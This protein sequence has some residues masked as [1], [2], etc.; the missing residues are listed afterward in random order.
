MTNFLTFLRKFSKGHVDVY[1]DTDSEH[2]KLS[3]HEYHPCLLKIET[4]K[5]KK[6]PFKKLAKDFI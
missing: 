6:N 1:D 3:N 2:A 4:K 5:I